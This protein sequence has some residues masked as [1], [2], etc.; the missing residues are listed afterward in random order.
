MT[1]EELFPFPQVAADRTE[2]MAH[3]QAQVRH[4]EHYH[5]G[6]FEL[7]HVMPSTCGGV[8]MIGDLNDGDHATRMT[9]VCTIVPASTGSQ[10]L[11]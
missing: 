8:A 3:L 4:V 10:A 7:H 1:E 11:H 9:F 2:A 6:K 5:G